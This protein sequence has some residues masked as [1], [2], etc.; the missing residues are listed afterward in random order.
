MNE[1]KL[2][3]V[4]AGCIDMESSLYNKRQSCTEMRSRKSLRKLLRR[5]IS[6]RKVAGILSADE[7]DNNSMKADVNAEKEEPFSKDGRNQSITGARSILPL[8][9]RSSKYSLSFTT[10][11]S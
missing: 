6:K 4:D 3:D 8:E 7:G 11:R 2:G 1:C 9:M 10:A 5:G